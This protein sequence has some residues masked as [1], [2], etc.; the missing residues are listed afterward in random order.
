MGHHPIYTG[1]T[2]FETEQTDLQQKLKPILEKYKTDLFIC[3][4]I[5]IFEHM[6][7]PGSA[8]DYIVNAAGSLGRPPVKDDGILYSSPDP[9]FL[10]CSVKNTSVII[11]LV[12]KDGKIL[13]QY[14]RT[15]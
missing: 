6:K 2:K 14:T 4:H 13:Y 9:G 10:L 8:I 11:T 1:T 5:Y 15:K 12:N 7:I 3:G